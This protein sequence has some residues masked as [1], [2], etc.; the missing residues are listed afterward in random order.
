[1]RAQ[2]SAGEKSDSE[3]TLKAEPRGL[4][5]HSDVLS[6]QDDPGPLGQWV[7]LPFPQVSRTEKGLVEGSGPYRPPPAHVHAGGQAAKSQP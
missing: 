7:E 4:A 5:D 6:V 1:M 3:C 2:T